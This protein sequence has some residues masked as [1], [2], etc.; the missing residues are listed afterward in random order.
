MASN[1]GEINT[2]L[3]SSPLDEHNFPPVFNCSVSPRNQTSESSEKSDNSLSDVEENVPR[4]VELSEQYGRTPPSSR[5][6]TKPSKERTRSVRRK[7]DRTNS[8][9]RK[10]PSTIQRRRQSASATSTNERAF[11]R[12][13]KEEESSVLVNGCEETPYKPRNRSLTES[14]LSRKPSQRKF[15]CIR[16][17]EPSLNVVNNVHF[18]EEK[19]AV[20][21]LERVKF[22]ETMN[23]LINLGQGGNTDGKESIAEETENY[24]I[25][26]LREALWLEIQAWRNTTTMLDQDEWLM[27]ERKKINTVLDDVIYFHVD[28]TMQVNFDVLSSDSETE[29]EDDE[30]CCLL[31]PSYSFPVDNQSEDND[32]DD[33]SYFDESTLSTS[34]DISGTISVDE[35]TYKLSGFAQTMKTAVKLV[36]STLHKLYSVEQLYPSRGA[37]SKDFDKYR[38]EEFQVSCDTLI[39]WLNQVKGLYHKLYIM[40]QLVHVDLE[41]EKVWEDWIELGIGE[42]PKDVNHYE[43]IFTVLEL[44][45]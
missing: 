18:K 1:G 5:S 30:G 40:S 4:E 23:M 32:I 38:S 41:D 17:R 26:E 7:K 21:P 29:S 6:F 45:G 43:V 19:P 9:L 31:H 14:S 15:Q 8:E 34:S 25:E 3:S 22:Y 27:N 36:T 24:E 33:L 10:S 37:L 16:Y 13:L 20:C 42:Y 11:N 39:L 12:S 44:W 2:E 35:D 28:K